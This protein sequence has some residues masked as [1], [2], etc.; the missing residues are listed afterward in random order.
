MDFGLFALHYYTYMLPPEIDL[1][2]TTGDYHAGP[3]VK[4]LEPVMFSVTV[5]HDHHCIDQ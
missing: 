2:M 1:K 3:V 5:S 4:K